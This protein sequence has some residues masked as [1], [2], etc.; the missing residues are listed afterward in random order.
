MADVSM[1]GDGEVL[2]AA[3]KDFIRRES[4]DSPDSA[5]RLSKGPLRK[6]PM[7]RRV[8]SLRTESIMGSLNFV[9]EP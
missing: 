2:T 7:A 3:L 8:P 6:A 4:G 1:T 5:C 9:A